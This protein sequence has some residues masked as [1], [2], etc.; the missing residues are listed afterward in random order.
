MSND[1]AI[2]FSSMVG[3]ACVFYVEVLVQFLRES[4]RAAR[5]RLE[6][7]TDARLRSRSSC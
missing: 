4:S 1:T 7:P 6:L 5:S 2:F 3:V